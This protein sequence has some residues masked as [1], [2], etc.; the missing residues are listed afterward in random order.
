M[1][2]IPG[3]LAQFPTELQIKMQIFSTVT[4]ALLGLC[5]GSFL[6]VVILRL[7]RMLYLQWETQFQAQAQDQS[8]PAPLPISEG[9]TDNPFNLILPASHCPQCLHKLSWFDN[10]P[11]LSYIW[12][13]GS[14]RY[15]HHKIS[16][17]YPSIEFL[18]ASLSV[19]VFLK[20]GF[21]LETLAGLILTWILIAISFID[22]DHQLIPDNLTLPGIWIGLMFN[23]FAVFQSPSAAILGAIAGYLAL[24]SIYWIFKYLTG[25]EGMGYG[26]FKLIALLGAW[27]GWQALPL[28]VMIA[29]FLGSI[30]GVS[31]ILAKKQHKDSPI[32][33]GPFLALGGWVTLLWG[34]DFNAWYLKF[35]FG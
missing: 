32:P 22:I 18:T 1:F 3:T 15:C 4:I 28:I 35:L 2:E 6:N 14:C 27:L 29:S 31:L 21:S 34:V 5:I 7:P 19:L 9:N 13:K 12:L 23:A 10:I 17:R 20:F 30:V 24:W 11:L 16:A 33:F 8:Q 26:D 25:K